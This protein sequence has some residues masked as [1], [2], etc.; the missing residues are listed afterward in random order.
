MD[1][2][3]LLLGVLV[4]TAALPDADGARWLLTAFAG[5]YAR[6]AKLWVDHAYAGPLV[7]WAKQ[8][9]GLDVE[10]VVRPP[11]QHGFQVLP[12]RWV[13]ERTFGWFGRNRR[14]S[15]DYEM[16]PLYS[17][18]WIYLASIQL[19]L[20]RLATAPPQEAVPR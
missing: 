6:L 11:E 13:V 2:L 15:K 9:F 5:L 4:T 10:I 16:E 14:L 3:G 7:A 19:M 20:K 12:R 8:R 17:E 1:T 18:S